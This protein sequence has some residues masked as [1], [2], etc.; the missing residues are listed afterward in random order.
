[1]EA[2]TCN[3]ANKLAEL[4]NPSS[5]CESMNMRMEEEA[6]KRKDTWRAL[7]MALP[8]TQS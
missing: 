3:Q 4:K 2:K 8:E 7:Y 1:M 6:E 5:N